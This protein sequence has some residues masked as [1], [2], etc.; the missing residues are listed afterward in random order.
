MLGVYP[1]LSTTENGCHALVLDNVT[2]F[3]AV[4]GLFQV[5]CMALKS[6]NKIRRMQ[7]KFLMLVASQRHVC[8]VQK[9]A[10]ITGENKIFFS[11]QQKIFLGMRYG[12]HQKFHPAFKTEHNNLLNDT[13][14]IHSDSQHST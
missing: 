3:K 4:L 8:Q 10:L 6:I 11:I 5:A 7:E 12:K 1:I 2:D 13:K 14:H 9:D